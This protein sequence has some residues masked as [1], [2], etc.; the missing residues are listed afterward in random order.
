MINQTI[1]LKDRFPFLGENGRDPILDTYI[2]I[3]I[4]NLIQKKAYPFNLSWWRIWYL[5]RYRG[6]T[7]CNA[8]RYRRI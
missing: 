2:P 3:N 8:L 7:H 5:F 1:H 6:R 4:P